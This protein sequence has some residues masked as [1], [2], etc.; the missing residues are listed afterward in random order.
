MRT[1][2]SSW[3]IFRSNPKSEFSKEK[4]FY[5]VT[6]DFMQLNSV[7]NRDQWIFHLA[8]FENDSNL[9]FTHFRQSNATKTV[10]KALKT[11]QTRFNATVVFFRTDEKNSL[12][13]EFYEMISDLKI[14]YKSFA[15]YISKQNDY[16][17]RKE[18][19]LAM[20]A[21]IMRI[22]IDFSIYLW[23]WIVCIVDFIMSKI[24]MKKHSW[25]ISFEKITNI[26]FNLSHLNKFEFRVYSFDKSISKKNKLRKRTHIEYFLKYDDS[27]IYFISIF[28]QR[29]VIRSKNVIF[30]ESIY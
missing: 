11:M 30:D 5:R 15:S 27:N 14:I 6:Y 25:K 8:C 19:V 2:K 1:I 17:E 7:M 26:K 18:R 22:Q 10:R 29:K 12:K 4:S 13:K 20:K 3:I 9:A 23:S 28:N 21:R 24:L 16:F